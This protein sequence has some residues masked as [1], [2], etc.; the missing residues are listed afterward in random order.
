M[1]EHLLLR[2]EATAI[3][4]LAAGRFYEELESTG[5]VLR[6]TDCTG[7]AIAAMAER[8]LEEIEPGWAVEAFRDDEMRTFNLEAFRR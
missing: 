7:R 6:L 2:E 5:E 8:R 4:V 3:A 1:R